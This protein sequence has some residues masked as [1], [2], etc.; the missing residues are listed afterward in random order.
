MDDIGSLSCLLPISY[1]DRVSPAARL[2]GPALARFRL[3]TLPWDPR[4]LRH[5]PGIAVQLG[6]A[7]TAW[8]GATRIIGVMLHEAPAQFAADPRRP[9]LRQQIVAGRP[10]P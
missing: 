3:R 6:M 9:R 2:T 5:G 7:R 8:A 10:R 4:G 1:D